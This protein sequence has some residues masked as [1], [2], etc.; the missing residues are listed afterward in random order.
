LCF[1]TRVTPPRWYSAFVRFSPA[2][3]GHCLYQSQP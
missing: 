2:W 3:L 1:A